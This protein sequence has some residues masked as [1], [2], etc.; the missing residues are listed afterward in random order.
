MERFESLPE[1]EVTPMDDE[2]HDE[3]LSPLDRELHELIQRGLTA[4]IVQR[5]IIGNEIYRKIQQSGKLFY[6]S[7]PDY[8]D[9]EIEMW[10]YF[11]RNLWEADTVET[12][13]SD[14]NCRILARLNKYLRMRL[15]DYQLK[16]QAEQKQREQL[17]DAD[18]QWTD[19]AESIPAPQ[20][21]EEMQRLRELIHTD[22]TGALGQ[23][24]V[25]K[26]PE[27]TA[28][29]LL[30]RRGLH[31]DGWK[32]LE[33]DLGVPHSTLNTFYERCLVLIKQLFDAGY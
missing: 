27:I 4:S 21:C 25:R 32:D 14:R 13:F 26:H 12:P 23:L 18:G 30:I 3:P 8:E 10:R 7:D 20:G 1:P 11:W 5:R 15:L 22:P 31:L 16:R 2:M 9:A 24:H 29:V 6:R 28:Q 19:I 33:R 17:R